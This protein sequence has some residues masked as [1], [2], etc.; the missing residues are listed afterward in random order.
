MTAKKKTYTLAA[1]PRYPL[2]ELLHA[3][4]GRVVRRESECRMF[5]LAGG[6]IE[7]LAGGEW[8]ASEVSDVL[9]A[10]DWRLVDEVP[11][12]PEQAGWRS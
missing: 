6:R 9:T 2:L 12:A 1:I 7:Q 5:R 3:H 10:T 8:Y 4:P 11:P